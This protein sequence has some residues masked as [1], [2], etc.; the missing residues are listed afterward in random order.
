MGYT[1]Q[2]MAEVQRSNPSAVETFF[3]THPS[4]QERHQNIGA[5]IGRRGQVAIRTG[6]RSRASEVF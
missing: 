2:R 6:R 1:P 4:L 5:L 3:S